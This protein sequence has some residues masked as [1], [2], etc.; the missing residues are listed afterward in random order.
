MKVTDSNVQVH[1]ENHI[2]M[3]D[4]PHVIINIDICMCV[5]AAS[6]FNIPGLKLLPEMDELINQSLTPAKPHER[7]RIRTTLKV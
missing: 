4:K 7:T 3:F 5:V 6:I 2:V 1:L